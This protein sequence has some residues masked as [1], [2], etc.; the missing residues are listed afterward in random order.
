MKTAFQI[1]LLFCSHENTLP[2]QRT[3]N[4]WPNYFA[5]FARSSAVLPNTSQIFSL[6]CHISQINFKILRC[7]W[8]HL[9]ASSVR[10]NQ[11]VAFGLLTGTSWNRLIFFTDEHARV[12]CPCKIVTWLDGLGLHVILGV[13]LTLPVVQRPTRKSVISRDRSA[14]Q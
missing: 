13:L 4:D 7:I 5:I 3:P 2:L 12:P 11:L 14:N 1:C 8:S 10:L 6:T 9:S